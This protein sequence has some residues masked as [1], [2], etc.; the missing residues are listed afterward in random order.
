MDREHPLLDLMQRKA[1]AWAGAE[2]GAERAAEHA[3][4][5]EPGWND[6]ALNYVRVFALCHGEFQ[7]EDVREYAEDCGFDPPPDKRAWGSV[8]L[9]AKRAGIIERVGYISTSRGPSHACP[10]AI[11]RTPRHD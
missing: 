10:R 7:T 9:R 11:W 1:A 5:V 6:T 2:D 4:R 8:A 3:E